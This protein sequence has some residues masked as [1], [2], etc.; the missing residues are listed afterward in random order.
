MALQV[1]ADPVDHEGVAL[2]EWFKGVADDVKAAHRVPSSIPQLEKGWCGV[3]SKDGALYWDHK[4]NA[5]VAALVKTWFPKHKAWYNTGFSDENLVHVVF[6]TESDLM[7]A[8]RFK[9]P[10]GLDSLARCR[11][12]AFNCAHTD[13][14]IKELVI[15]ELLWSHMKMRGP[16]TSAQ[17]KK[18]MCNSVKKFVRALPGHP[19]VD[20]VWVKPA[21]LKPAASVFLAMHLPEDVEKLI[22]V[23]S[24][25]K[26]A[27][28]N[29]TSVSLNVPNSQALRRCVHCKERGHGGVDM[30]P[31]VHGGPYAIKLIFRTPVSELGRQ[32][33]EEMHREW[34]PFHSIFTG[35]KI[36]V[37]QPRRCVYVTYKDEADL[38]TSCQKLLSCLHDTAE[39]SVV[40]GSERVKSCEECGNGSHAIRNCPVVNP[41]QGKIEI[42]QSSYSLVAS[43][44]AA[45][46]RPFARQVGGP[47]GYREPTHRECYKFVEQGWCYF[48]ENCKFLHPKD[49]V[50]ANVAAAY[51]PQQ[52]Q[53]LRA[54]QHPNAPVSDV[55]RGSNPPPAPV[56]PPRPS[57][58]GSPCFSYLSLAQITQS[59]RSPRGW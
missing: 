57:R 41:Q 27:G 39:C 47:P 4:T 48:G 19:E 36:G 28:V 12:S 32:K 10:R 14:E 45:A 18:D 3:F 31:T 8:M 23:E 37:K 56:S 43:K 46:P 59:P 51:Q 52:R 29:A 58:A 17:D 34:G 26:G 1:L 53:D 30:C 16:V 42:P 54:Q 33:I 44:S 13:A 35:N 20:A 2:L 55:Q 7:E 22:A 11:G 49:I 38:K 9:P 24:K 6:E 25:L 50:P 15:F 5:E 21:M 40:V